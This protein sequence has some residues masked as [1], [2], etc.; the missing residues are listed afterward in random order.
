MRSSHCNSLSL[1]RLAACFGSRQKV[2]ITS[3]RPSAT[4][5]RARVQATRAGPGRVLSFELVFER[6]YF[7]AC[8]NYLQ[9]YQFLSNVEIEQ[10]TGGFHATA[11]DQS[12]ISSR[13]AD[14]RNEVR[15][16][17]SRSN[18]HAVAS[19][20]T[21]KCPRRG[22]RRGRAPAGKL[23]MVKDFPARARP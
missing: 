17:Q 18:H 20:F 16:W 5:I 15:P 9:L 8:R 4:S 11:N 2:W 3:E 6:F 13:N 7:A 1:I 14:G 21:K 19:H 23:K 10:G 12:C 22:Q